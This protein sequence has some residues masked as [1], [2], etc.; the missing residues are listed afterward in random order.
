LAYLIFDFIVLQECNSYA[1]SVW[2]R[3]NQKLDGKDPDIT[4]SIS[5]QEQVKR[6]QAKNFQ[7]FESLLFFFKKG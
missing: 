3:V 4:K 5:V 7:L 1:V 6:Q 2:R